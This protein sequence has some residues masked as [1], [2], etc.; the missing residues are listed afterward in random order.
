MVLCVGDCLNEF[1]DDD[2]IER[3]IHSRN[4]ADY[5]RGKAEA[6]QYLNDKATYGRELAEAWEME[7]EIG[8]YN[9]G[10]G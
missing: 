1:D 7:A 6:R 2:Y 5:E 3:Q 4:C 10:E 8:R 9:R